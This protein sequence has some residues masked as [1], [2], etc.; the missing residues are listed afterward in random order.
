MND[1]EEKYQA[2]Q[3]VERFLADA[4]DKHAGN[5]GGVLVTV[6][7]Q[8][9]GKIGSPTGGLSGRTQC[10]SGKCQTQKNKTGR[11]QTGKTQSHRMFHAWAPFFRDRDGQPIGKCHLIG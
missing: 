6:A 11:Y 2:G 3:E 8:A 10:S 4:A 9:A 5:P 1:G 7:F